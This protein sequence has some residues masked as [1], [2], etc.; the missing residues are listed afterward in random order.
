MISRTL[1][2]LFTVLFGTVLL[3]GVRGAGADEVKPPAVTLLDPGI[4][5]RATLRWNPETGIP[6]RMQM[7]MAMDMSLS[8]EGQAMPRVDLPAFVFDI[9]VIAE[10]PDE[11]GLYP[12]RSVYEK[13]HLEGEIEPLMRR[14]LLDALKPIEGAEISFTMDDRGLIGSIDMGKMPAHILEMLGGENGARQMVE[15]MADP[16]PEEPVGVGARWEVKQSL[17]Q[18][19][20]PTIDS[21]LTY[22]LVSRDGNHVQLRMVSI[23]TGKE[24][25]FDPGVPGAKATLKSASGRYEGEAFLR[26]NRIVPINATNEGQMEFR[27]VLTERG[28]TQRMDQTIKV[29]VR[30]RELDADGRAP[31]DPANVG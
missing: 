11:N 12:V 16:M 15:S 10:E 22:Q 19:N 2:I 21:V 8:F 30:M 28:V 13:V 4:G 1:S 6:V 7:T 9:M 25:E 31:I 18:Q 23:Q 17:R 26:L 3:L 27:F 24:Q 20:A 14:A 29:K 5:E